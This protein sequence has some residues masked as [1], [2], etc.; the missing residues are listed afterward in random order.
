[1]STPAYFQLIKLGSLA[2]YIGVE[3][4]MNDI[5]DEVFRLADKTNTVPTAEDTRSIWKDEEPS[6]TQEPKKVAKG[7]KGVVIDLFVWKRTE[8]LMRSHEDSWYV[9]HFSLL[10]FSLFYSFIFF[11]G[12][13]MMTTGEC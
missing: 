5:M 2:D 4:C 3:K 9:D 6:T 7:L 10:F 13:I 1:M 12:W 8:V 11:R